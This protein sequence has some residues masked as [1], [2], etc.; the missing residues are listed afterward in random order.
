MTITPPK[1]SVKQKSTQRWLRK[2]ITLQS[3]IQRSYYHF[4]KDQGSY[5][6]RYPVCKFYVLIHPSKKSVQLPD[7]FTFLWNIPGASSITSSQKYCGHIFVLT[8]LKL[9]STLTSSPAHPQ[10]A[11]S[12]SSKLYEPVSR[13]L[14]IVEC[15]CGRQMGRVAWKK[16]TGWKSS[17]IA[18]IYNV[19][20]DIPWGNCR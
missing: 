9:P 20:S 18:E 19:V 14:A 4:I 13:A 17:N 1:N 5:F 15:E 10:P 16:S 7:G 8:A 11:I 6:F 3:P 2:M 12:A